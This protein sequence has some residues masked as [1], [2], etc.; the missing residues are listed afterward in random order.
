MKQLIQGYETSCEKVMK[1]IHQLTHQRNEL[2]KSGNEA[3][4]DE[5]DLERRIRLLYTEH[6]QMR[7]VITYLTNYMRRIDKSVKAR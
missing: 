5:L 3:E 4:I 1:R 6:C 2:R 7:E